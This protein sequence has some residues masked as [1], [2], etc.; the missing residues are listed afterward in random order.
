ME[1][2]GEPT[3]SWLML[4]TCDAKRNIERIK[5]LKDS[6]LKVRKYLGTKKPQTQKT[7]KDPKKL[8]EHIEWSENE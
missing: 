4:V 3:C 1:H 2:G 8:S 6:I 7:Q 5:T